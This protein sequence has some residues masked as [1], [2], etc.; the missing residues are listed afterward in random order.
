MSEPIL[1]GMEGAF[2]PVTNPQASAKWYEEK[3]GCKPLYV[4]GEAVTMKLS[5]ESRTV[6][7]LVRT[8]DLELPP[9]THALR[10]GGFLEPPFHRTDAT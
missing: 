6:I 7:T 3:L 8:P 10:G 5:E 2:I 4:E 9:P 1:K